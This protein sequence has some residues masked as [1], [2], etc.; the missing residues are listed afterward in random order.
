MRAARD[1]DE[2][3]KRIEDARSS[4]LS[5]DWTEDPDAVQ[6]GQWLT[7]AASPEEVRAAYTRLGAKFTVDSTGELRLRLEIPLDNSLHMTV[8]SS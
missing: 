2:T 5:S 1:E 3:S 6:P 4:L 8:T 7:L